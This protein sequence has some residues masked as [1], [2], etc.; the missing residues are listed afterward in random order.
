MGG[1]SGRGSRGDLVDER[2]IKSKMMNPS[3]K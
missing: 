1:Q 2:K 3:L